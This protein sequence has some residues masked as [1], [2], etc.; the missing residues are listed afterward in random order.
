M[1]YITLLICI[2]LL[3]LSTN[4]KDNYFNPVFLFFLLWSIIL[5]FNLIHIY[6]INSARNETYVLI[7]IGLIALFFGN[8]IGQNKKLYYFSFA[9]KSLKEINYELR[10]TVIYVLMIISAI[11][12]LLDMLVVIKA[13][14]LGN[15]LTVIRTWY[16]ATYGKGT[17]PIEARRGFGEQVLRVV[18]IEP[19]LTA[20]PILCVINMFWGKRDKRFLGFSIIIL[21]MNVIASGGGRLSI[22]TYAITFIMG[23]LIYKRD[24]RLGWSIVKKYKKFILLFVCLGFVAVVYLTIKRSSTSVVEE[25]YYYFG[26][27]I[28]LFDR[29]LP[30]IES[31]QRTHAM[32]SIFGGARIPFL[33]MSKLG[34]Q[35]YPTYELALDYILQA[36]N[37]YSV[38]ARMGN[39][40]V[41]PFY[42]LYLDGGIIGIIIGMF[43]FGYICAITYRK[44]LVRLDDRKIY[45]LLLLIQASLMSFIRWQFI[46]TAFFM[47]FIYSLIFFKV[48]R[49]DI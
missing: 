34:S 26:M 41:S 47:S 38:G 40:F 27:C 20:L 44:S 1:V 30:I 28:P 39:S 14:I 35:N 17:N 46:G 33:I 7:V 13:L 15:R 37:F 6:G 9:G 16:T 48:K 3:F 31:A 12:L 22:L 10:Y 18:L 4:K 43:V 2:F 24:K 25:V 8:A 19:F 49:E 11:L 5:F 29:W 45:F 42:Y 21:I 23:F 32:L 36:N